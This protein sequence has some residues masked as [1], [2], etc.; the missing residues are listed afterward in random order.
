MDKLV[1]AIQG[2]N[3]SDTKDVAGLVTLLNKQGD[4]FLKNPQAL[5]D[6]LAVLDPKSHTLGWIYIM[7]AKT[8]FNIPD[9]GKFVAQVRRLVQ[10]GSPVQVRLAPFKFTQVCKKFTEILTEFGQPLAAIR[11]LRIA[12][13]KLRPTSESLTPLHADFFQVCLISKAYHAALPILADEVSELAK[14]EDFKLHHRDLLKYFYYGGLIYVGVKQYEKALEFFKLGFIVP[15]VV[16]SAI[17]VES[18]KKFVLVSLILHGQLQSVPKYTSSIV[19]RH[20]KAICPHYNDFVNAYSTNSTDE[21]H[22]I[23]AQHIDIFRKDHNFGLV[24]QAIQALYRK[25]IK[26]HTQ[27]YLT[28]SLGDIA[29]SVK[30]DSNK[31]AEKEVLGMIEAGEIF[32]TINQ[33][34]GM[35][36]FSENPE[37]VSYTHLTLPTTPYV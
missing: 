3:Y 11:T 1:N 14:P 4:I 33:K 16:L 25:N 2:T 24:K 21:V 35:V 12:I 5:D 31:H 18:Y 22:K 9:K 36:S 26:R 28:L 20:L 10:N 27:T 6:L 23:A 7:H 30:L 34:D 37:P 32:A 13:T 15:S 19:Q 29:N 17:M 8:T